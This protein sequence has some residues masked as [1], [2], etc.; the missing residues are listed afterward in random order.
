MS[1]K[2]LQ[3]RFGIG[4]IESELKSPLRPPEKPHFREHRNPACNLEESS[5]CNKNITQFGQVWFFDPKGRPKKDQE[6]EKKN[7]AQALSDYYMEQQD[8]IVDVFSLSNN[9]EK[10]NKPLS[11][12][13][14][15]SFAN[16]S[17]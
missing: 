12:Q 4:Q 15:F 8:A 7:Y 10:R 5:L 3:Q 17:N 1:G 16:V 9:P 13:Q 6:D 14:A 2:K 11:L